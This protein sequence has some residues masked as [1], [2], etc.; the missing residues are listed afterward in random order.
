MKTNLKKILQKCINQEVKYVLTH[1]GF[2][3]NCN[4]KGNEAMYLE[5]LAIEM[6]VGGLVIIFDDVAITPHI[7]NYNGGSVLAGIKFNKIE[8]W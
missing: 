1:D 8:K 4:L 6:R 3:N 5:D 7:T 2:I